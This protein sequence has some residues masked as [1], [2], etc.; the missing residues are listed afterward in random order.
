VSILRTTLTAVALALLGLGFLARADDAAAQELLA[1]RVIAANATDPAIDFVPAGAEHFVWLAADPD[2]RIQKLLVFMPGSGNNMPRDWQLLGAEAARLGYHT[3]MLAYRND[4]PLAQRC[5]GELANP[6]SPDC[7]LNVRKEILDGVDH[8]PFP[9][10]VISPANS[11]DNRLTKLLQYLAA[12]SPAEGWAQFLDGNAPKWS[13]I[14][15]SGH[16]LGGAQAVLIGMLRPVHRVVAFGGWADARHGWVQLA[17]TA[18]PTPSERFFALVHQRD[19]F[20]P[21]TCYAY[22]GLGLEPA[23][24]M[25]GHPFAEGG[26]APYGGRHVVVTNVEPPNP[27]NIPDPY[28]PAP[29][30]DPFVPLAADGSPVLR[31]AWRYVLGDSDADQLVDERD[32]CSLVANAD[33]ADTDR[34]G[35][36]DACDPLQLA[37]LTAL[38]N[39]LAARRPLA[40]P[41]ANGALTGAVNALD[42]ATT[43]ANW[44]DGARPDEANGR[45]V[46]DGLL[47]AARELRPLDTAWADDATATIVSL[48]AEITRLALLEAAS[49][50][51]R[52]EAEREQALGDGATDAVLALRHFR[53]AWALVREVTA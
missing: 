1:P 43:G 18:P 7:A 52:Q 46:Y 6:A 26:S 9:N 34:D 45:E 12:Q 30:R 5:P 24:P 32:N 53:K 2:R 39:D 36:G 23:C 15:I 31:D 3:I 17:A 35:A 20:F 51:D 25:V 10:V 28:H 8:S 14:A 27:T 38:R 19:Q 22:L 33:Q 44:D 47:L 4:S 11:I 41:K 48:A 37:R 29:S 40:D 50:P 13:R 42:R 21:R 49:D 16:S